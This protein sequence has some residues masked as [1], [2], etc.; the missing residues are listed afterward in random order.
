MS[1]WRS[2]ELGASIP[3]AIVVI[4]VTFLTLAYSLIGFR[5]QYVTWLF[6]ALLLAA[7]PRSRSRW[8]LLPLTL[9]RAPRSLVR[10]RRI[11][12][13][14][15]WELPTV[16]DTWRAGLPFVHEIWG[17]SSFTADAFRNWLP[18]GAPQIVRTVPIT[19]SP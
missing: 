19:L 5:V 7:L 17:L 2:L 18:P 8:L 11:I 4:V 1:G 14:W 9:L 12:G 3:A 15:A 6:L 16:P 13:Y 10:G